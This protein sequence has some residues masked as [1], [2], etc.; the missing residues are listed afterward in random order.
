MLEITF[1]V[2]SMIITVIIVYYHFKEPVES[3][4]DSFYLR[5]CP[6]GYNTLFYEENGD[7]SCCD[8]ELQNQKCRHERQCTLGP[9]E[10][11]C[12]TV[13][14][15]EYRKKA[16]QYCPANWIYFEDSLTNIKGCTQGPLNMTL[17]GPNDTNQAVCTIFPDSEE[18]DNQI[19]SCNNQRELES[20]PC[21]GDGC[22][23]TYLTL[24]DNAPPVLRIETKVSNYR[25]PP[26]NPPV[27]LVVF[28]RKSIER[29]RK[30]I[31]L[32]DINLD[33][34]SNIAEVAKR[35]YQGENI[36]L[37]HDNLFG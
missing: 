6:S 22:A 23:K 17:S 37:T 11:N 8:G 33:T 19:T 12:A 4:E 32:P 31:G 27:P 26:P 7:A 16:Q 18:N 15:K 30:A 9:G 24:K 21:F 1:L 20:Y 34:N 36:E 10:R 13:V 29:Y 2:I 3:F 28:T 25:T 35:Y 5:S 14:M